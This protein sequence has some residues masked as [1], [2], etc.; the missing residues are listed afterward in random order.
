MVTF[1]AKHINVSINRSVTD[2]Y[3]YISNPNNLPSWASGLK[4]VS[5]RFVEKN[6]FGVVDH[7][8]TLESGI[9]LYMP[10]RVLPNH[11]GSEVLFTLYR[12]PEMSDKQF[13]DDA[14]WVKKDLEK[15]K[16]VV[17]SSLMS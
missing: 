2:V 5:V 4:N 15:L 6:Q 13:E 11:D 10:M 14:A 12:R 3:N 9:S 16:K 17:E 8:V 1:E 7:H